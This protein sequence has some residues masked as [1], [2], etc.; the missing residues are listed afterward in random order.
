MG[1][2]V[3]NSATGDTAASQQIK[4]DNTSRQEEGF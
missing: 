3:D 1:D 2:G 4:H